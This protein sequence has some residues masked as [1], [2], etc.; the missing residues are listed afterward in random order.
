MYSILFLSNTESQIII[1]QIHLLDGLTAHP[2]FHVSI[3]TENDQ[4]SKFIQQ[5]KYMS[6]SRDPLFLK[7]PNVNS[8]S[9]HFQEVSL[10]K[11]SYKISMVAKKDT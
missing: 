8:Y 11:F 1:C 5:I 10:G 6:D 2:G 9:R 4:V 7:R 3:F